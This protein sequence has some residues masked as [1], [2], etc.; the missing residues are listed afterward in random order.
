MFKTSIW[1]NM[2]CLLNMKNILLILYL[3]PCV[4][5]VK[6]EISI[7]LYPYMLYNVREKT[8]SRFFSALYVI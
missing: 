7:F 8:R 4:N 1:A 3:T 6:N 5:N 2:L